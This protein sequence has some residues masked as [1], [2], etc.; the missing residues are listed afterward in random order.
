MRARILACSSVF[1]T[2]LL[3]RS[4][5]SWFCNPLLGVLF[6]SKKIQARRDN[7]SSRKNKR[8]RRQVANR[9]LVRYELD[10]KK[11]R[12]KNYEL[13]YKNQKYWTASQPYVTRTP[14]TVDRT[15][16][17]TWSRRPTRCRQTA[18][19]DTES[20]LF[21][22]CH[23]VLRRFFFFYAGGFLVRAD[24]PEQ[25]KLPSGSGTGTSPTCR[26]PRQRTPAILNI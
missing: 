5:S 20:E 14:G 2:E 3:S 7:G 8:S 10:S 24:D 21:S 22:R 11:I 26:L 1:Q 6:C 13:V 17:G 9:V 4:G 12:K 15:R 19:C 25:W 23:T 18:S 16:N